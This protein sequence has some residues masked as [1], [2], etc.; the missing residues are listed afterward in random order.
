[1]TWCVM[2]WV[3]LWLTLTLSHDHDQEHD[4]VWTVTVP[5]MTVQNKEP[6][7]QYNLIQHL[8][9]VPHY[10][11]P[12][13]FLSVFPAFPNALTRQKIT[14]HVH[15]CET[16]YTNYCIGRQCALEHGLQNHA[17]MGEIPRLQGVSRQSALLFR[18]S[19]RS[20]SEVY[21]EPI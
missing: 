7:S 16:K 5:Q 13:D 1:M 4:H 11:F 10:F 8:A 19:W 21:R 20:E 17:P 6:F 12:S 14:F 15:R 2:V 9:T 3:R 18:I